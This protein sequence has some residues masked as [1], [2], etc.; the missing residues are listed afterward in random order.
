MKIKEFMNKAIDKV[1]AVFDK[2]NAEIKKV[3]NTK[4]VVFFSHPIFG[5]FVSK[6]AFYED[7]K[8]L[9]PISNLSNI[10]ISENS[11]IGLDNDEEYYVITNF[12]KEI[13]IKEYEMDEKTYCYECYAV[14]Y[15][16]LNDHFT[17]DVQ[18]LPFCELSEEQEEVLETIKKEI[19]EYSLTLKSKKE[20]CLNL[21][22]FFKEC[23]QYRIKDHYIVVAFSRIANEYVEDYP[24]LLLKLF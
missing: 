20:F 13:V 8:L 12:S 7:K 22:S 1:E 10:E 6:R 2:G 3:M 19:L 17:D 5:G 18:N 14:E 23:V 11:I 4:E 24:A 15:D 21:W 16:I 9:F